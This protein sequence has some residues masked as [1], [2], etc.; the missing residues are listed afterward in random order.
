MPTAQLTAPPRRSTPKP[1]RRLPGAVPSDERPTTIAASRRPV[2]F[3]RLNIK[4]T[5]S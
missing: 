3:R 2:Y 4:V 5:P 1:Y